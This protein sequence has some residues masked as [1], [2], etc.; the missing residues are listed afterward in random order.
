MLLVGASG[1]G[2]SSAVRAG[3]LP[4]LRAGGA[5][6]SDAWFVTTMLPG[7]APFKEL[8][9]S[10]SGIAVGDTTGLAQKLEATDGIDRVLR[11]VVPEGGQLL[12]VI[13]QFEELFTLSPEAEQR[14][15]LE[16]LTH[17]LTVPDSRLRVVATLRADYFDRPLGVQPFGGLVQEATVTIPAMLPAELEAAVVEPA[18]RVD[19]TVERAL[20]AELVGSLAKEPAALPALQFVLYELAER[21]ADGTLSLAAYR[22]IGGIDGAIATRAESSISSTTPTDSR[23]VSS[24]SASS[25]WT[26][27]ASQPADAQAGRS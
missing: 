10:L 15:F 8:A 16:A 1:T 7:G 13:D 12:L 27:T 9:Q 23:C 11:E 20:A 2:K 25:W 17:A 21:S 18:R 26:P 24:S 22:A 3:L 14:A 5:D 19:R 6:G 4:R